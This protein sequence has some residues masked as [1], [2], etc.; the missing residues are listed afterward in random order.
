MA[1]K[2]QLDT[3]VSRLNDNADY[4]TAHSVLSELLDMIETFNGAAEYEYFCRTWYQFSL[5][6]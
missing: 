5:R 2:V 6:T 3:F 4:K 1:Y